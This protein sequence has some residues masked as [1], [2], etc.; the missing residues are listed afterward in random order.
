MKGRRE[1]GEDEYEV[2]YGKP[3]VRTRFSKGASGN[4]G[5]RPRGLTAGRANQLAL[6]EA[7]R[8]VT[9][10]DGTKLLTMPAIQAIVRNWVAAAAKGS[11]PAQRTL[12]EMIRSIEREGA[13]EARVRRETRA[14]L[15]PTSE[16][17]TARRIAFLLTKAAMKSGQPQLDQLLKGSAPRAEA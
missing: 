7:Y 14:S 16:L 8:P 9:A 17:D 13:A 11:G 1:N 10:R 15:S 5:G 6:K 3:P 4:P 12:L 2:G